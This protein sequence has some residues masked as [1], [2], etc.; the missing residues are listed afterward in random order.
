MLGRVSTRAREVYEEHR[1]F[2]LLA[3]LFTS[4][5]LLSLLLFEPGGFIL[6][7]SGYYVPGANF[8]E[9][10]DR[11]YYP[12]LHYWMEY[13]PLFPWLSVLVY[14]FSMLQSAPGRGLPAL[15]DR[16]LHPHLCHC[17]QAEG[18]PGGGEMRVAVCRAVLSPD[19][20]ALLV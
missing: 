3:L 13:P 7:W 18:P 14:R 15:R 11:G 2:F 6:D 10:S 9:L 19:D 17:P 1:D 16:Q 4:F 5:R 8:V 12:V 20:A